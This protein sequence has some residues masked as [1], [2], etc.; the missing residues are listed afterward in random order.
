MPVIAP[1]RWGY[2]GQ[3]RGQKEG[4]P[5]TPKSRIFSKMCFFHRQS[6]KCYFQTIFFSKILTISKQGDFKAENAYTPGIAPPPLSCIYCTKVGRKLHKNW[7]RVTQF[8]WGGGQGTFY[9][10]AYQVNSFFRFFSYFCFT[11][12]S[13]K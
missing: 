5:Q 13:M 4:S 11:F 3:G 8:Y 10:F 9:P 7:G 6:T 12:G 1:P 2:S